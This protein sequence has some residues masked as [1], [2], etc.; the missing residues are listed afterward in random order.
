MV[1]AD[2]AMKTLFY[3]QLIK[4]CNPHEYE[5]LKLTNLYYKRADSVYAKTLPVWHFACVYIMYMCMC[6][7]VFYLND[8]QVMDIYYWTF[9][10]LYNI[11]VIKIYNENK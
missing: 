6:M 7:S 10:E 2:I 9:C 1:S 4:S 8:L 5:Y 3:F 11:T